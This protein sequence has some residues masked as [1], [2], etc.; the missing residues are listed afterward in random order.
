MTMQDFRETIL[1]QKPATN[2]H[3]WWKVGKP[4]EH[5]EKE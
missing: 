4:F 5:A 1:K 3:F 2:M